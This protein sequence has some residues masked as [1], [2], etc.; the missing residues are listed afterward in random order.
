MPKRDYHLTTARLGLSR[1]SLASEHLAFATQL[2]GDPAVMRLLGGPLSESQI[3]ARLNFEIAL[4]RDYAVQ[5]WP[6]FLR[7]TDISQLHE[8]HEFIGCCGLRPFPYPN[9]E[10]G[11]YELG[12]HLL[13][14][15]WR[16]GYAAEAG[17]AA[18]T[19][20]FETLKATAIH[21]GH[22]P[23]NQASEKLIAAS[24]FR[25][26]AHRFYPP[27]GLM[28]PYYRLGAEGYRSGQLSV[29]DLSVAPRID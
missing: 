9:P 20:A 18:L 27:T 11:H 17:R 28:H 21:T 3:E 1:W 15:F 16:S 5:Y 19:Y 14:A 4:N 26:L 8:P 23:D 2:W 22:H 25:Y 24:H 12:A 7:G 29:R 6:L 13:P 10:A